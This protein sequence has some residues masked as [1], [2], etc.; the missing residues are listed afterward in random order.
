MQRPEQ[1]RREQPLRRQR[2]WLSARKV[3]MDLRKWEARH[4]GLAVDVSVVEQVAGEPGVAR[5]VLRRG[6]TNGSK[7]HDSFVFRTLHAGAKYGNK[8]LLVNRKAYRQAVATSLS[9]FE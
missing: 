3:D 7:T 1:C 2:G 5:D 9:G 6:H 8:D 4:D